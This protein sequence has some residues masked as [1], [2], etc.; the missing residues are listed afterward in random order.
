M[1]DLQRDFGSELVEEAYSIF[2][3]NRIT[4][5]V[6]LLYWDECNFEDGDINSYPIHSLD[7]IFEC[8]SLHYVEKVYEKLEAEKDVE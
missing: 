3:D 4:E 8:L 1:I 5:S 7:D 6:Q 2:C